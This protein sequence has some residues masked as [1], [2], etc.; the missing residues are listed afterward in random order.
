MAGRV[1]GSAQGVTR[2]KACDDSLIHLPVSEADLPREF[3]ALEGRRLVA[4]SYDLLIVRVTVSFA[5]TGSS[6]T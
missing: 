1:K 2:I 3:S 6:Q 5:F 4:Q